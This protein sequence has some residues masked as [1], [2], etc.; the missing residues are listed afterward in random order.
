MSTSYPGA[1][2]YVSDQL[3]R[4]PRTLDLGDDVSGLRRPR[5]A[6]S[7]AS[8]QTQS[9]PEALLCGTYSESWRR[10]APPLLLA[11]PRPHAEP[12]PLH[13]RPAALG[14]D[15]AR[16][17]P[18]AESAFRRRHEQPGLRAVPLDAD[19][20]QRAQ[21]SLGV[22]RQRHPQAAAAGVFD[23]YY[24]EAAP[25]DGDLR[26]Q[27]RLDNQVPALVELFPPPK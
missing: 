26:H 25:G 4:Y 23:A 7:P 19:R 24:A 10:S 9:R 11:R 13:L 1:N 16:G 5:L 21:R 22:H 12:P 3:R 17:A 15:P 20:D 27:P 6:G 8:A 14:L 18:E 2:G